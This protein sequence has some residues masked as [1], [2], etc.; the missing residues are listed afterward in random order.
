MLN[1]W[2]N[3]HHYL[4]NPPTPKSFF[5]KLKL[6]KGKRKMSL[7]TVLSATISSHTEHLGV[8]HRWQV[9]LPLQHRSNGVVNACSILPF[10]AQKGTQQRSLKAHSLFLWP[11][12]SLELSNVCFLF[13]QQEMPVAG[14]QQYMILTMRSNSVAGGS[15]EFRLFE[16]QQ[17]AKM[18]TPYI[19][20][21]KFCSEWLFTTSSVSP[22]QVFR[23][24]CR[25]LLNTQGIVFPCNR[26]GPE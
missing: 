17:K 2:Y 3:S 4:L 19:K 20:L 15:L 22:P 10:Q 12:V 5:P 1:S 7:T 13:F 11:A 8:S 24:F 14:K 9:V 16:R 21:A 23:V 6:K 26:I 25:I 18:F